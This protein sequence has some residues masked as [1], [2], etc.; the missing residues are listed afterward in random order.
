[1]TRRARYSGKSTALPGARSS[2]QKVIRAPE[3]GND[4]EG[5]GFSGFLFDGWVAVL[6]RVLSEM[7]PADRILH[8][9]FREESN[10]GARDRATLTELLYGLLRH[11]EVVTALAPATAPRRLGLAY[12]QRVMGRSTRDLQ[13]LCQTDDERAWLRALAAH[14]LPDERAVRAHLPEWVMDALGN[15]LPED[16]WVMLGRALQSAAPLDVRVNTLKSDRP[17]VLRE[18]VEQGLLA[19]P[20]PWSPWGI[21]VEGRPD[22][23]RL[24]VFREGRIEV[25]D[26]G[27]QL[28]AALVAPRRRDMV[29]DFC[30]GAGGKSLQLGALMGNQGRLYAMDVSAYRLERLKPRLK[31]A[32]LSNLMP[33]VIA[34]ET[35][36]RVRRLQGKIDRVLVDAPCTGMGTLRRNPDLKLRQSAETLKEL[37]IKQQSILTAA[38]QL[39]KPG[40]RLVYAT[41]SLLP[42]ENQ[43][44]VAGF[45]ERHPEFELLPVT[46]LLEAMDIPLRFSEP[47]LQLWPHRQATDGFFAAVWQRRLD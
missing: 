30:A 19:Q 41:C 13:S 18:L 47:Y 37:V 39:V 1:M 10:W 44:Q 12:L 42:A 8:D 3:R 5:R 6:Q 43:D 11:W 40:G 14:R 16:E 25:Q 22:L 2:S 23:Q 26:E 17:A 20:T 21:R 27:S 7:R 9:F 34:R 46:P 35:D 29:V 45:S 32:G 36:D 31:R 38:A 24:P 28:L 15:V 4:G 33:V